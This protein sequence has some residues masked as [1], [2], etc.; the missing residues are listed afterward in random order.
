MVTNGSSESELQ[1]RVQQMA[2]MPRP[3]PPQRLPPAPDNGVGDVLEYAREHG[4]YVDQISREFTQAIETHAA[5]YLGRMR[6]KLAEL[7]R[8]IG[9]KRPQD[10]RG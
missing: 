6:Q 5:N 4:K 7:E 2:P 9:L 8:V 10:G 3:A 1:A